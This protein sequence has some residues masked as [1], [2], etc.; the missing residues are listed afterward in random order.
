MSDK[1]KD[2]LNPFYI[3]PDPKDPKTELPFYERTKDGTR[4]SYAQKLKEIH[5]PLLQAIEAD[6]VSLVKECLERD[7]ISPNQKYLIPQ[8][9]IPEANRFYFEP[10]LHRASWAGAVNVFK[11]LLKQGADPKIKGYLGK[12]AIVG[13]FESNSETEMLQMGKA[14]IKFGHVSPKELGKVFSENRTPIR[15][16]TALNHY[17]EELKQVKISVSPVLAATKNRSR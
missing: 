10:I 3:L 8:W 16:C 17:A 1:N 4:I 5:S 12:N 11:E 7:H 2:Y 14:L 13:V 6:D 15:V 9:D